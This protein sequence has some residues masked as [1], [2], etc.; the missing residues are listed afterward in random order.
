MSDL[1][2]ACPVFLA[3]VACTTSSHSAVRYFK[4]GEIPQAMAASAQG[5][6]SGPWYQGPNWSSSACKGQT[7]NRHNA[8]C[9][10]EYLAVVHF[11]VLDI[12]RKEVQKDVMVCEGL[13][14]ADLNLWDSRRDDPA[15]SGQGGDKYCQEGRGINSFEERALWERNIA[16][17]N[18]QCET[19]GCSDQTIQ[20][21]LWAPTAF[22]EAAMDH[23]FLE[24]GVDLRDP[25]LYY[26]TLDPASITP[27]PMEN[28]PFDHIEP[29]F[30]GYQRPQNRTLQPPPD[31]GYGKF[32]PVFFTFED[33]Q[34]HIRMKTTLPSGE[35]AYVDDL[36]FT[37]ESKG[38]YWHTHANVPGCSDVTLHFPK[39]MG[40]WD[41][42]TSNWVSEG[43]EWGFED[44]WFVERRYLGRNN[45][46]RVD[47]HF[48]T[49]SNQGTDY[50]EFQVPSQGFARRYLPKSAPTFRRPVDIYSTV[51]IPMGQ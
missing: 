19:V 45:F 12:L 6:Y 9:Y 20:Q 47:I 7:L 24:L 10:S 26:S 41:P 30:S 23:W 8:D 31:M 39:G 40:K 25:E 48:H 38:T 18:T 21:V 33:N 13:R 50:I 37:A 32:F 17:L 35:C 36:A 11:F 28:P 5:L 3:L 22:Y 27:E 2:L 16:A 49:P 43:D 34:I 44:W 15:Y 29:K 1:R 4:P 42:E 46:N 51:M 14:D